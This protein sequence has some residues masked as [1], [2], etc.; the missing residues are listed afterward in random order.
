MKNTDQ[1]SDIS[2]FKFTLVNCKSLLLTI[3]PL[4]L[5][6]SSP[7]YAQNDAWDRCSNHDTYD[8]T[9]ASVD[10]TYEI[11][12][13]WGDACIYVKHNGDFYTKWSNIGNSLARKSVRPGKNNQS[14]DFQVSASITEGN[15]FYGAYGWW[16]NENSTGKYDKAVE[17]YVVENYDYEPRDELVETGTLTT[18]NGTYKI[19]IGGIDRDKNFYVNEG[20]KHFT[21]IKAIRVNSG[22]TGDNRRSSGRITMAEHFNKWATLGWPLGRLDE[23]AFKVEGYDNNENEYSASVVEAYV[24]ATMSTAGSYNGGN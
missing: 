1:I 2:K 11:W 22:D 7:L 23:V 5:F 8:A 17:Y 21:Q 9:H 13:D 16:R 15:V 18:D 6:T 4:T 19:Y 14:I 3:L 10:Y 24:A 20:L 12:Q